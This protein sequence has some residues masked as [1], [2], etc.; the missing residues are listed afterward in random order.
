MI[1]S[2]SNIVADSYFS[3]IGIFSEQ[4]KKRR[5]RINNSKAHKSNEL[6]GNKRNA[7]EIWVV[8]ILDS[9]IIL[10]VS[11]EIKIYG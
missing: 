1:H 6:A 2:S 3:F 7:I 4:Q 11:N 5:K 8:K 9:R 10:R